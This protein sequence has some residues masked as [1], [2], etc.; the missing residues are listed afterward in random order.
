MASSE[1]EATPQTNGTSAPK[2]PILFIHGLWM[3]SA[4]WED[5]GA[6]F[7][8]LGHEVLAPTWPGLESRTVEDIRKDP[9]ALQGLTIHAIVEHYAGIIKDL[10]NP[11]VLI[12][13]S[14]GGLFVQIL[15]SR[16]LGLAG[17]GEVLDPSRGAHIV[18]GS[19]EPFPRR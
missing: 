6:Y 5:W 10:P 8:N 14:F 2:P 19:V 12:G 16:G 9:K 11:P 3:T 17:V 7:T 15:L 1:V 4:C 18:A 13:H